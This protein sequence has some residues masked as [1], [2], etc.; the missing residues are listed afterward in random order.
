MKLKILFCRRT[1]SNLLKFNRGISTL[2]QPYYCRDA[3]T[4]NSL[5]PSSRTY[6]LGNGRE[7]YALLHL[8]SYFRRFSSEGTILSESYNDSEDGSEE[9]AAMTEFLSRFV[10]I[11]RGKLSE[12]YPRCD[13]E[14]INGMLLIIVDKVVGEMGKDGLQ[15]MPVAG[16]AN[17][18]QD[19]S[20]DLW[21]TVR[22]V[23]NVVL[24][25]MQKAQQKE[26]LKGFL[27][28]EEVKEMCRF[29]GEIGIR[30]D[31]LR[32]LRFKWAREKMEESEFYQN[33]ESLRVTESQ[34]S[35]QEQSEGA[36]GTTSG[37][38]G[39]IT[40]KKPKVVSLPKRHGK[41]KYKIYGLDLSDPRWAEVADKVHQSEEM[42]WPEEPKP[43][44]GRCEIITEKILSLQEQDDPSPLL[45][46]W[47]ELLQPSRIDWIALLE[48]MKEK[49]SGSY[50][51]VAELVLA[52]QSFQANTLDYAKLIDAHTKENRLEDAQRII[53]KMKENGIQPAILMSSVLIHM[54]SKT[55]NL[56]L[57]QKEYRSMKE[58]GLQP[59]IRVYK[60]LIKACVNAGLPKQGQLVMLD[61]TADGF[62]PA[63]EDYLFLLR[64]FAQC[65]DVSNAQRI[66]ANMQ[67]DG[68]EPNVETC[69]LLVEAY[70]R[71]GDSEQARHN[72]DYMLRLGHKPD[73]KSTAIL[74]A[75]Y[76]KDNQLD[77]ALKLV[78]TLE[79][80]N[81]FE[82]G[83]ATY[84]V[85]VDW[86]SKM[87]LVEEVEQILKKISELGEVPPL[88]L[89]ISLCDMYSQ[90]G[91]EK[92]TLQALGV[93]ESKSDQLGAKAFER[94]IN[95]LLVGGFANDAKRMSEL[96]EARGFKPSESLNVSKIWAPTFSRRRR[97]NIG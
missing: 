17:G 34:T 72:F 48:K 95:A 76:E 7:D 52:E 63:L 28:S 75:A 25:D 85:L 70:A 80:E 44:S 14:T 16:A 42:I 59:D 35:A 26:K 39:D 40:E 91:N 83:V 92:K 4:A 24:D 66:V 82:P 89:Q 22:E 84:T 12:A 15:L 62:K 21:N 38:H 90:V 78:L 33:L 46:E 55:G 67:F 8:N 43:I 73:D 57:A 47:V 68:F 88:D 65:G 53:D 93:I 41:I 71:A 18:S 3:A 61:M 69:G 64:S 23:S 1:I 2:Q 29:A 32:E 6:L 37:V 86:L 20:E 27:Q 79:K 10:W 74:V 77:E 9:D 56:E 60:S 50:L 97:G 5:F 45:G 54:Y 49:N 58:H 81:G 94:I 30:G 31:M 11:M 51:K 36:E 87:K 19:L 13:K 96:M